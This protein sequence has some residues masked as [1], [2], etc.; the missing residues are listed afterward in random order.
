[1][2]TILFNPFIKYSEKQLLLA[3]V[4]FTITGTIAGYC[5]S[6]RF[7]GALDAHISPNITLAESF[8]DNACNI[9][10]LFVSLYLAARYINKKTRGIDI[11]TTILV[12]RLPVYFLSLLNI[13]NSLYGISKKIITSN[14]YDLN[15]TYTEVITL[16]FYLIITLSFVVW[17]IVLLYNGFKVA[18]N[19][20]TVKHNILF[21]VALL[22]AEILS[23]I[24]ISIIN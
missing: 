15:L 7:D 14:P 4:L 11:L 20:K 24:L 18:C 1:M 9:I 8:T 3:G 5:F 21:A 6:T 13:G 10:S 17:Y 23:K 16:L 12:A 22:V 19:A 2:K